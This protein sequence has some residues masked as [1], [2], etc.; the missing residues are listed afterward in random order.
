MVSFLAGMFYI[1]ELLIWIYWDVWMLKK[2]RKLWMKCTLGYVD[3]TWTDMSL[4]KKYSRQGIIGLPWKRISFTLWKIVINVKFMVISFINLIQIWT[5]WLLLGPLFHGEWMSSNRLSQK[6][7]MDIDL[8]WSQLITSP[9]V[10]RRSL[11]KQSLR[12]RSRILSI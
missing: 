7:R 2:P 4:Q 12:R 11:S 6:P 5:P 8:F 3:H 9:N 10:W 1:N